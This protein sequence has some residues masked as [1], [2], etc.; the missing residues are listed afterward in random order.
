M[1]WFRRTTILEWLLL[2][3]GTLFL[4]WPTL[5]SDGVGLVMVGLAIFMQIAKNKKE[6]GSA[7]A[8]I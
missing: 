2:A 5:A 1:F 7:I 6:L 8:P 3:V 4:Y